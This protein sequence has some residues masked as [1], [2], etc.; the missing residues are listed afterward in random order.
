MARCIEGM[1]SRICPLVAHPVY[2]CG[3]YRQHQHHLTRDQL[4]SVARAKPS[5]GRLPAFLAAL[6]RG[7]SPNN[8]FPVKGAKEELA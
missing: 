6:E 3:R 2:S 8:V 4:I 5:P 1:A 7:W